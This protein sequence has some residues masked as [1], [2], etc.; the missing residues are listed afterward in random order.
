MLS[1]SIFF[2]NE[3]SREN[4]SFLQVRD[5]RKMKS[6][7]GEF[8]S[9]SDSRVVVDVYVDFQGLLYF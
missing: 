4:V 3:I 9:V 5:I 8:K 2:S 6:L 1:A 7:I